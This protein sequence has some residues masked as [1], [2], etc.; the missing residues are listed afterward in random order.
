M[1]L[2]ADVVAVSPS[3]VYRVLCNA[4]LMKAHNSKPSLKGKG[5]QQPLRPHEHW[6]VDV[7]YVNVAGTFFYFCSLL[8]GCSRFRVRS[9]KAVT[10]KRLEVKVFHQAAAEPR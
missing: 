3:S 10:R 6:H 5:F 4:G 8:D 7:T 2:D 1:M 9:Q